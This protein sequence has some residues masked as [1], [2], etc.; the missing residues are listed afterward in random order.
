MQEPGPKT[1]RE[2]SLAAAVVATSTGSGSLRCALTLFF[3]LGARA[4]FVL[5]FTHSIPA[6]PLEFRVYWNNVAGAPGL[7]VTDVSVDGLLNWTAANLT[8]DVGR[9]DG[10]NAWEADSVRDQNSGYLTRGPGTGDLPSGDYSA[11][12][13]LKVD[14]FYGDNLTV[15]NL[16]VVDV[17]RNT[18]V[19][20]QNLTR[21]QFSN[22]LY[23]L[24]YP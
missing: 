7:T 9:L 12:F 2:T 20:I 6:A 15:A 16:S 22:T 14:N 4:D 5:L 23:R 1:G 13:E 8:H 11:Q 24:S 19:A 21:N 17:G 18:V 10:L 3:A